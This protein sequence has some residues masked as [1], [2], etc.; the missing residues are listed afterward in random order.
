VQDLEEPVSRIT[1]QYVLSG[2][3]VVKVVSHEESLLLM[4]TKPDEPKD[5]P[6]DVRTEDHEG[7][8]KSIFASSKSYPVRLRGDPVGHRLSTYGVVE[9][10]HSRDGD[11]AV[12]AEPSIF[13]TGSSTRTSP[14]LYK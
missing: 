11:P 12:L 1:S 5:E 2:S 14:W 4:A 7:E 10:G 3:E 6:K 9:A 8:T 13:T